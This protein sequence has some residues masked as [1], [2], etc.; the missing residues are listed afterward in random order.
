[1]RYS[2]LIRD[3]KEVLKHL[4][5]QSDKSVLTSKECFIY[6][7]ERWVGGMLANLDRDVISIY[8][9]FILVV[10]NKFTLFNACAMFTISPSSYQTID[11][12]GVNC[13]EFKFT[14]GSM[15]FTNLNLVEDGNLAREITDFAVNVGGSIPYLTQDD[16]LQIPKTFNSFGG[17][18]VPNAALISLIFQHVIRSA[19]DKKVYARHC[20]AG[21]ILSYIAF[22]NVA[23]SAPDT[24]SK[25]SGGYLDLGIN[26]S[27]INRTEEPNRAEKILR[28]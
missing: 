15:V 9:L 17:L 16:F 12:D 23:L 3:K 7:P 4:R 13:I 6:I 1:M 27:L 10:G 18:P 14:P 22:R 5:I 25:I 20:K 21:T 28:I 2:D 24:Y 8:G 11:M 26:D 19:S